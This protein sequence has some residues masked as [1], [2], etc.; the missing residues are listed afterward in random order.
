MRA[1]LRSPLY[2][3]VVPLGRFHASD[4]GRRG[5]GIGP[6]RL[7]ARLCHPSS[8]EEQRFYPDKI[9]V[10]DAEIKAVNLHTDKF[11][12]EWNYSTKPKR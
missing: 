1:P 5:E 9:K 7:V 10:S 2:H 3:F 12:P 6:L 4:H 11:H 8:S